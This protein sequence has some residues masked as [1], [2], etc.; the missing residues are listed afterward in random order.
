ML[1]IKLSSTNYL[2]WRSQIYPLLIGQGLMNLI[3]GTRSAP[4]TDVIT[5]GKSALNPAYHSWLV[6]DQR[7]ESHFFIPH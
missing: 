6:D 2:L 7:L 3:D 4:C 1:T 5:D